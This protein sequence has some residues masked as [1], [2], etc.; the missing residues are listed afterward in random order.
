MYCRRPT[1]IPTLTPEPYPGRDQELSF[2]EESKDMLA[3]YSSDSG[4]RRRVAA[5]QNLRGVTTSLQ[6]AS[7]GG[8]ARSSRERDH[9]A[10]A[11]AVHPRPTASGRAA[12]SICRKT[13][14]R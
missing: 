2:W 1:S 13:A 12:A 3:S 5:P 4:N 8:D 9:A 7:A 11:G 6:R 10:A 14:E